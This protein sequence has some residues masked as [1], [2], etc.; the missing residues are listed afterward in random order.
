MRRCSRLPRGG[1]LLALAAAA[2]A[3]APVRSV[4]CAPG[5][6]VC[7]AVPSAR[8]TASP[9]PAL[10]CA[11]NADAGASAPL[12]R[13]ATPI[14]ALPANESELS[15]GM[16]LTAPSRQQVSVSLALLARAGDG[17]GWLVAGDNAGWLEPSE[18]SWAAGESG[19]QWVQL[20]CAPEL[21][22]QHQQQQQQQSKGMG[23]RMAQPRTATGTAAA[24]G[25]VGAAAAALLVRLEGAKGAEVASAAGEARI[26]LAPSAGDEGDA[27]LPVFGFVPN[28]VAYCPESTRSSS[29]ADSSGSAD[30]VV[31]L[32]HGTLATP[33]TVRYQATLLTP[34]AQQF[35]PARA[36]QARGERQCASG[37]C[38]LSGGAL[39]ASGSASLL[40]LI[41]AQS[42]PCL[43]ARATS[44]L[45][46]GRMRKVQRPRARSSNWSSACDCRWTGRACPQRQSTA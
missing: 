4:G 24:N 36:M 43:R 15:L 33:A 13:V 10:Q 35:V 17:E 26:L 42:A 25:G 20:T 30:M 22:Q 29:G 19:V 3:L 9:S 12:L 44:I 14:A 40:L 5:R 2:A 7:G 46:L 32:L 1:V 37:C 39:G 11:A 16:E 18:L 6:C 34:E 28:Q 23:A 21:L 38:G 8:L 41:A 27:T 31:R 45:C